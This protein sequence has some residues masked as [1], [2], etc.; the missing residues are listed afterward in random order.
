MKNQMNAQLGIRYKTKEKPPGL[1]TLPRMRQK[2]SSNTA[3]VIC[4][5]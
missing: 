5:I 2:L 1:A 3:A 4:G